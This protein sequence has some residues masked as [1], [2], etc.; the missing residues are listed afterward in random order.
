MVLDLM[1][2]GVGG[3]DV[4]RR[5]RREGNDVPILMLTA[6]GAVAERVAGP[7][8][9]RRRL[10]GQAVRDSRSSP[11][12]SRRI[13][14]RRETSEHRLSAGDVVLDPLE[15]RVWVGQDEVARWPGASSRCWT[16]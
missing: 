13:A 16:S 5:L 9:G 6:R 3:L 14:R 4:C 2:P 15:Q 8:G 10:P 11:P 12:G 1:L 7:G